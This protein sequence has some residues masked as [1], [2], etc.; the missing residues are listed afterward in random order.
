MYV[1]ELPEALE[2]ESD[3]FNTEVRKYDP[4]GCNGFYR[5]ESEGLSKLS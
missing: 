4:E 3:V 2:Q 5:K 1:M